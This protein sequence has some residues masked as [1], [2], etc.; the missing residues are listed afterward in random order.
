MT[1]PPIGGRLAAVR[2]GAHATP[3]KRPPSFNEQNHIQPPVHNLVLQRAGLLDMANTRLHD[4]C[5]ENATTMK[6]SRRRQRS[7][8]TFRGWLHPAP[9][10]THR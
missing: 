8:M 3:P 9:P 10:D 6:T 1:G 2:L 4:K 5:Q 7:R